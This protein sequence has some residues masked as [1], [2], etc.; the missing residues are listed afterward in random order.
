MACGLEGRPFRSVFHVFQLPKKKRLVDSVY[1]FKED[2]MSL[3]NFEVDFKNHVFVLQ[4]L[5]SVNGEIRIGF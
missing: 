3:R 4:I 5:L 1:Y 2:E